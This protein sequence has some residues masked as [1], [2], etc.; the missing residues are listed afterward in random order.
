MAPRRCS[1]GPGRQREVR[2][3]VEGQVDLARRAPEAEAADR[4]PSKSG[5]S[6]PGSTRSR[7]VTLASVDASTAEAADLLARLEHDAG[8]AAVADA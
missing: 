5:S 1:P 8:R 6:V 7:K 2:Q 4:R 3:P